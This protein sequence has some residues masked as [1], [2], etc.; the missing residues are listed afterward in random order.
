MVV[1]IYL[2]AIFA[3]SIQCFQDYITNGLWHKIVIFMGTN[4]PIGVI[5]MV[6]FSV[7]FALIVYL[8]IYI[9]YRIYKKGL[10]CIKVDKEKYTEG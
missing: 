8:L 5:T 7:G 10:E 9:D 4:I 3:M 2:G 1:N 6:V